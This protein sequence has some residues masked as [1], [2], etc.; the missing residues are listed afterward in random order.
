MKITKYLFQSLSII[1][2]AMVLATACSDDTTTG[3]ETEEPETTEYTITA[4][5]QDGGSI[6]PSGNVTV[7]EG[8]DQTFD[9]SP[10]SGYVIQD[11][12]ID[13]SS[14]GQHESYTFEN[15]QSDHSIEVL[16]EEEPQ[17]P[18]TTPVEAD[19][20]YFEE[21][22]TGD[23]DEYMAFNFAAS[24]AT[25]TSG[26]MQGLM[27][28]GEAY[29]EMGEDE[30]ATI[31]DDLWTWEYTYDSITIRI[32]AEKTSDGTEWNMYLDGTDPETDEVYDD[33]RVMSG[34]KSNDNDYGDWAFYSTDETVTEPVLYYEWS[35][36]SETEY[37]MDL[38]IT[39]DETGEV[40][41]L[42][43]VRDG[44]NNT[45]ESS[46]AYGEGTTIIYWNTDNNTGYIDEDGERMCWNDSF[47]NTSCS[48]VG[49]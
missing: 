23:T 41:E 9:I 20:S 40:A 30:D 32:T 29:F 6:S 25:S 24:Y 19:V 33:H 31:E 38:T 37:W 7:E 4:S 14:E 46:D 21:A 8:D 49:Y 44:H 2:L 39:D 17:L 18:E 16:F 1:L 48:E 28:M 26:F 36:D 27:G 42:S 45:I 47:V 3:P 43:Y 12:L 35:V 11:L 13:G 10:N 15:V 5:A 34:F 22:E